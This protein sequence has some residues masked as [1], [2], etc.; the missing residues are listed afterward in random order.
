MI[1]LW[2]VYKTHFRLKGAEGLKDG[3]DIQCKHKQGKERQTDGLKTNTFTRNNTKKSKRNILQR[4]HSAFH[5]CSNYK[6]VWTQ[7]HSPDYIKQKLVKKKKKFV[8]KEI[9]QQE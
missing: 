9:I 6:H 7:Q 3:Q 1:Q 4:G 8:E 5:R 2:G